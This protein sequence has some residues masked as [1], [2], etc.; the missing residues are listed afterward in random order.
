MPVAEKHRWHDT[1]I[2]RLITMQPSTETS[3]PPPPRADTPPLCTDLDG[4]LVRTDLLFESL[5]ALLRRNVL[6][7]ALLPFWLL[8]GRANLKQQIARRVDL[9]VDHLPWQAEFLAYLR[10]QHARGRRLV[11]ATA[12]N[13][14]FARQV[15]GHLG[16]FETVLASDATCNLRGTEKLRRIEQLL[17]GRDFDYAGNAHADLPLMARAKRAL[18]VNPERGMRARAERRGNV[19][20]VFDDRAGLLKPCLKAL[21][22]HQWSKNLLVF[23]P[24]VMTHRVTEWDL[25]A[26]AAQA[27]AAFCLCASSVYLLNDL[28]DA[29]DD[30]RHPSKADRPFAQGTL[31]ADCGL[32]LIPLLLAGAFAIAAHLP[33]DFTCLLALYY[34]LTLAYSLAL[35]QFVLMDVLTLVGLYLLRII[36]GAAAVSVM[37]SFWLLAFSVF[38]FVSLALV[39]RFAELREASRRSD[40]GSAGRGYVAEDAETL[41]GFGGASAYTSVLVLAL[42]INSDRVAARYMHPELLWLL[43]PLLLYLLMRLWLLARRGAALDDP[44][45]FMLTCPH[46]RVIAALGIG[47]LYLAI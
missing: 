40:A 30:R 42:Y 3:P 22:L 46:C 18:L 24:L 12:S 4:T 43:C 45:W 31:P 29:P 21:R 2:T 14:K 5:F 10:D 9:E 44:V 38:V 1:G 37:P 26:Q 47:L 23:V 8:G 17:G 6:Y 39:K 25:L 20:R 13:A 7:V 27:F 16:I 33:P 19:E 41:S 34:G 36:A 28:L 32:A 35:R 11:L 15:A